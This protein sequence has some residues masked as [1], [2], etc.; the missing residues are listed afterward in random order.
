MAF[1]QTTGKGYFSVCMK[2]STLES[3]SHDDWLQES[4]RPRKIVSSANWLEMY[5]WFFCMRMLY[6][7]CLAQDLILT[8]K[9]D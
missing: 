9:N 3:D 2:V 1:A 4:Q 7:S 5:T 8:N 6:R